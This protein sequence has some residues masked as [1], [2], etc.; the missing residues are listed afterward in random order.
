MWILT[1]VAC[2]LF[3]SPPTVAPE[4]LVLTV[5]APVAAPAEVA[6]LAAAQVACTSDERRRIQCVLSNGKRLALCEANGGMSFRYGAPGVELAVP[7]T[8][9]GTDTSISRKD[10]GEDGEIVTVRVTREDYT[11]TVTS[12]RSEDQFDA[13]FEVMRGKQ[14]LSS[15]QCTELEGVDFTELP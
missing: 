14:R 11:Y 3:G 15:S 13:L 8:G 10:H 9:Y 1:L 12:E 5:P 2:E 6:P 7:P 4:P